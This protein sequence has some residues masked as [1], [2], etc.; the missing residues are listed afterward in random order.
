MI[1]NKW[2][3][4]VIKRAEVS[5]RTKPNIEFQF[6]NPQYLIV[7]NEKFLGSNK[8]TKSHIIIIIFVQSKLLD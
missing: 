3:N 5:L 8:F 7:L 4:Q 2:I 6:I 1:K